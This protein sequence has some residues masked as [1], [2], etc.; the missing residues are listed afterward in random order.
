M[1]TVLKHNQATLMG[2]EHYKANSRNTVTSTA[3][4]SDTFDREQWERCFKKLREIRSYDYDWNDEGAV[5]LHTDVLSLAYSV[6][7]MLRANLQPAPAQCLATEE[8]HVIFIWD[9]G[10]GYS[11]V[12]VDRRLRCTF[13]KLCPGAKRAESTEFNPYSPVVQ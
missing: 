1:S 8:G 12:E 6:A 7:R 13:R 5:P 10:V 11:E 4:F 3:Y 9:E 2:R